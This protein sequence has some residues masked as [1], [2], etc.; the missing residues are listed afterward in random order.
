[1][2]DESKVKEILKYWFGEI[3]ETEAYQKERMELWFGGKPET[4]SE[5][6]K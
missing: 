2:S 1:M 5:I 3:K 6:R 4:D